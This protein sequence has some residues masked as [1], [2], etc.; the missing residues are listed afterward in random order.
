MRIILT[1]L[2]LSL[3]LPMAACS[4]DASEAEHAATTVVT[5]TMAGKA[6]RFDVE[7]ARSDAEQKQ[8]LKFR[9]GLPANGGMLFPFEKPRIASFWMQDTLIPLDMIFIRADGSIDRIA[10]NTIPGSLEPV[11]SGG[12]VSAVLELAGG[13]AARLGIDESASVTWTQ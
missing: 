10:E 11:A 4:H 12:E 6:H 2:A 1:A 13:T 5:I 8:G 3:A 7:V 9:T